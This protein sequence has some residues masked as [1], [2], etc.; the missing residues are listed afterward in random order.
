MIDLDYL[1]SQIHYDIRE[2]C[3]TMSIHY[4]NGDVDDFLLHPDIFDLRSDHDDE[5]TFL[6]FYYGDLLYVIDLEYVFK[7]IFKEVWYNMKLKVLK[8]IIKDTDN[9]TVKVMDSITGEYYVVDSVELDVHK[10]ILIK[11]V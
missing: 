6:L 4:T 10:D 11:I 2:E 7:I 9:G 1:I 5:D 3:Y 8:N